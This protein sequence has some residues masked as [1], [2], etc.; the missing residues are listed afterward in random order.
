MFECIV[1]KP[2]KNDKSGKYILG[3]QE[4]INTEEPPYSS[5]EK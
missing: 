4:Y 2:V 1:N 5:I 3:C